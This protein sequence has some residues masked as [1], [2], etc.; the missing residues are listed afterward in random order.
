MSSVRIDVSGQRALSSTI[1][2]PDATSAQLPTRGDDNISVQLGN[3][4]GLS[5]MLPVNARVELVQ[6]KSGSKMVRVTTPNDSAGSLAIYAVRG[7]PDANGNPVGG[8]PHVGV[9][10]GKHIRNPYAGDGTYAVEVIE[11]IHERVGDLI[12]PTPPAEG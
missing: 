2:G 3:V 9:S 8:W 10:V 5:F 7:E 12:P 11:V 4:P 6:S 1:N